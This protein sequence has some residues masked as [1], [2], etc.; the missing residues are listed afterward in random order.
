MRDKRG[1]KREQILQIYRALS[2]FLNIIVAERQT[3]QCRPNNGLT[4]V[5][6][7]LD[8]NL[9]C[10]ILKLPQVTGL[11]SPLSSFIA[12]IPLTSLVSLVSLIIYHSSLITHYLS[13]ITHLLPFVITLSLISI[14]LLYFTSCLLSVV[15]CLLSVIC[16]LLYLIF[17]L[18][19]LACI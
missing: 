6:P 13:L 12:I 9:A 2:C 3:L 14:L 1:E 15:Y 4:Q 5:E 11:S 10:N 18:L 17:C 16:C 19:S 7:E 8:Q